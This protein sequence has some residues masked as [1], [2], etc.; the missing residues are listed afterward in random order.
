MHRIKRKLHEKKK[1]KRKLEI[2]I[3][4]GLKRAFEYGSYGAL[5]GYLPAVYENS[6]SAKLTNEYEN[7]LRNFQQ[8]LKEIKSNVQYLY[9]VRTEMKR[10]LNQL[11]YVTD[12]ILFRLG[13]KKT[14]L[15][16]FLHK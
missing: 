14:L 4:G 6:A 7:K 16:D 12:N 8:Q 2:D 5:A 11:N 13:E 9:D 1:Q 15:E 3:I 10:S